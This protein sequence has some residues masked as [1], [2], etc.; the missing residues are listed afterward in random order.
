MQSLPLI[1]VGIVTLNRAWIIDKILASLQN[2]TYP[3]DK[4]FVVFVDGGSK[5]GTAEIA[6]QKLAQADF[7]GYEIIVEPCSIPEG[8]NICI[9]KMQGELLLYWDSDVLVETTAILRLQETLEQEQ[10][11]LVTANVKPVTINSTTEIDERLQERL[12]EQRQKEHLNVRRVGM[13]YTLLTRKLATIIQFDP[14]LTIQEDADFCVRALMQGFKLMVNQEILGVDINMQKT[15]NS[16]IYID[17]SMQDALRGIRKKGRAQVY[18]CDFSSGWKSAFA[19]FW[20][21][22]R[23]LFYLGYIVTFA[24]LLIGLLTWNIFLAL[25]FPVYA[26]AFFGLQSRRRGLKKGWKSFSRSIIIG[27]PTAFW[28]L[29]YWFKAPKKP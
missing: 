14:E 17:M 29:V 12:G 21:N 10:V 13:G 9:Q 2:Q 16:D 25:V 6:K 7:K 26:V 22:K 8:R 5:D 11:D 4:L 1:T 20:E 24:C 15:T 19:F 27:I 23:Y 18:V 3:H 28:V